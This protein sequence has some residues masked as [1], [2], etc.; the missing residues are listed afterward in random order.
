MALIKRILATLIELQLIEQM[1]RIATAKGR[2]T[3]FNQPDIFI[4]ILPWQFGGEPEGLSTAS[5]N[6]SPG[7]G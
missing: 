3:A 7:L 6:D 1:L 2:E 5:A 4:F